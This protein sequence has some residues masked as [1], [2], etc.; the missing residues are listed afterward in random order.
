MLANAPLIGR[1]GQQVLRQGTVQIHQGV[2]VELGGVD[3]FHQQLNRR[4]VVQDHLGFERGLAVCR[5]AM[6]DQLARIKARVGVA[7]QV[8]RCP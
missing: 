6:L 4:L 7:F 1:I 2:A 5:L 8:A 3:V